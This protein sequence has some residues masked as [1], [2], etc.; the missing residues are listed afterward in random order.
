MATVIGHWHQTPAA[1][2][3]EGGAA[4]SWELVLTTRLL[5]PQAA[6]GKSDGFRRSENPGSRLVQS[7]GTEGAGKRN[8][9]QR[10]YLV[11]YAPARAAM[12]TCLYGFVKLIR[13]VAFWSKLNW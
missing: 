8:T 1:S 11:L 5:A 12:Q 13:D 10:G 3:Q 2:P 6:R 9:M 4:L 7:R